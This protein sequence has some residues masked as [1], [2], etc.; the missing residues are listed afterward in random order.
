MY[1]DLSP[2]NTEPLLA[3]VH[4]LPGTGKSRVLR[5]IRDTFEE[6]LG[7]KHEK[8]IYLRGFPESDGGNDRGHNFP[9]GS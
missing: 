3:L 8:T 2:S 6:A 7:W 5:W 1:D 4:G 9:R